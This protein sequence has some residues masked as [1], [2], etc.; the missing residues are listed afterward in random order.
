MRISS[1]KQGIRNAHKSTTN[2]L[3]DKTNA[4][5][6]TNAILNEA[7]ICQ[8]D[9]LTNYVTSLTEGTPLKASPVLEAQVDKTIGQLA[10]VIRE[11]A[12]VPSDYRVVASEIASE[13]CIQLER[14]QRA[15]TVRL[16]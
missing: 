12:V 1:I 2:K 6:I 15:N 16:R 3:F 5:R 11:F 9:L 8:F 7:T 10:V 13:L 4:G 14:I